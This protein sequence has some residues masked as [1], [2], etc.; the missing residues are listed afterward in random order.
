MRP[1]EVKD[2]DVQIE[3]RFIH[4]KKT[5]MINIRKKKLNKKFTLG[6]NKLLNFWTFQSHTSLF[7]FTN[8]VK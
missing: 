4:L 7:T 8:F 3:E 2:F 6:T 1:D 5:F